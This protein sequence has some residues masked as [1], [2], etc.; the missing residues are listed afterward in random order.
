MG[1]IDGQRLLQVVNHKALPARKA[2]DARL[3]RLEN[4]KLLPW[5]A[6]ELGVAPED[7]LAELERTI[8][9]LI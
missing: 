5:L 6:H 3:A 1:P 8:M 9:P 7:A 2:L 4:E